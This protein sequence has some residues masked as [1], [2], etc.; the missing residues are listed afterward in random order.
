MVTNYFRVYFETYN[1]T[2]LQWYQLSLSRNKTGKLRKNV[3]LRRVSTTNV[4]WKGKKYYIVC[5]C[6]CVCVCACVRVCVCRLR[7]PALQAQAPYSLS[8]VVFSTFGRKLLNIKC[9]FWFSLQY[10]SQKF[11]ILR[12]NEQDMIKHVY[13]SSRKI[14]VFLFRIQSNSNFLNKFSKNNKI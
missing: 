1:S 14:S 7:Y 4:P 13:W 6:V 5:V 11:L 9:V 8:S 12:R 3:I 2:L 10:L